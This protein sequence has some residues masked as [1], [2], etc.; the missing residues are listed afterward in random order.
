M[1]GAVPICPKLL[2]KRA[3]RQ[4]EY[5]LGVVRKAI[6][7]FGSRRG[8]GFG[9]GVK[10][11]TFLSVLR[12]QPG[13]QLDSLWDLLISW[14]VTPTGQIRRQVFSRNMSAKE[15]AK[16]NN[17]KVDMLEVLCGLSLVC[18]GTFDEK[19]RNI[20][21]LFDFNEDG[22]LQESEFTMLVRTC[23]AAMSKLVES[24]AEILPARHLMRKFLMAQFNVADRGDTRDKEVSYEELR[25]FIM[26]SPEA[27]SY[28]TQFGTL[29]TF[30]VREAYLATQR[31]IKKADRRSPNRRG[32]GWPNVP[33]PSNGASP[34][35][36]GSP[37][38]GGEGATRLP[39]ISPSSSP[40]A[41]AGNSPSADAKQGRV[42]GRRRR[43]KKKKGT[44]PT[45]DRTVGFGF[46]TGASIV[47][48]T[49]R[50]AASRSKISLTR[51]MRAV[52]QFSAIDSNN[53]GVIS[54]NELQAGLD[55]IRRLR[56]GGKLGHIPALAQNETISFLGFLGI[57][58]PDARKKALQ[59]I[60][61]AFKLERP[62]DDELQT[63]K[64]IFSML[65]ARF[66]FEGK[67][68][69]KDFMDEVQAHGEI[70]RYLK[71]PQVVRY[72]QRKIAA[73][74]AMRRKRISFKDALDMTF[75]RLLSE[76]EMKDM[77][78]KAKA[79]RLTKAESKSLH[80]S[81]QSMGEEGSGGVTR[82]E[83]ISFMTKNGMTE[84][85]AAKLFSYT[86]VHKD[87]IIYF[88]EF[89][90]LYSEKMQSIYY[91]DE[92]KTYT[93]Q[94]PEEFSASSPHKTLADLFVRPRDQ[95]SLRNRKTSHLPQLADQS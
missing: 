57:V 46:S 27:F 8:G 2:D 28:M 6:S 22:K 89:V 71:V 36:R 32:G 73:F 20:F 59:R 93:D 74:K 34:K 83:F 19:L 10:K 4:A 78:R 67:V 90:L 95:A 18:Q 91:D 37:K 55:Q 76:M 41:G 63:L 84:E 52:D 88:P 53:D 56:E 30:K 66:G 69:I 5:P 25:K 61:R 23:L 33:S 24:S 77:L 80:A 54:A 39:R 45:W 87:D 3:Q 81:F 17:I 79:I 60:A 16:F 64:Q 75:S 15:E 50:R 51:L 86:D 42:N 94:Q 9:F 82:D 85:M 40:M 43:G 70:A 38:S 58:F 31:K 26:R 68:P 21:A 49:V 35:R 62:S 1:G 48:D 65:D 7:R 72:L 13:H 12:Y 29:D 47:S 92:A 11:K 44:S 14:R